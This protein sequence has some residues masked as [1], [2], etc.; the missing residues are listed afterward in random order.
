MRIAHAVRDERGG[1]DGFTPGDQDKKE[2]CIANYY[3]KNTAGKAWAYVLRAKDPTLANR[4]A[5]NMELIA[6]NDN[7]GYSQKRRMDMYNSV[8]ANGG[9]ITK[10]HGD[11][12]CSTGVCV[13]TALAGGNV[14]PKLA[15]ST[16][17]KGFKASGQ[18]DVLID[19]IYIKSADY[20]K[21]GDILLRNGHTA[22][23]IDNGSK[24]DSETLETLHEDN[25]RI[26]TGKAYP[27]IVDAHYVLNGKDFGVNEWCN[28][29]S[30]PS[31][32]DDIIGRAYP[33]EVFYAF[34]FTEDWYQ[35]NYHGILGYIYKDF[36]SETDANVG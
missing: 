31:T 10:A 15:T 24:S 27:I 36:V 8:I 4:I 19:A 5:A 13:A 34:A 12:D 25:E 1:I 11:C 29:R 22:V 21:R 16:M 28:V 30:G 35:I 23:V 33:N 26:P 3:A 17:L 2:V 14:S 18:F 6:A 20:L 9:D 32:D 7:I